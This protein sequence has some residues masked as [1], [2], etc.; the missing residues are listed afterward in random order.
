M[1]RKRKAD[2]EAGESRNG[3]TRSNEED[4]AALLAEDVDIEIDNDD[5]RVDNQ[6]RQDWAA[7]ARRCK[8]SPGSTVWLW[9]SCS[10]HIGTAH[11]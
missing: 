4:A 8:T 7:L 2:Q 11:F 9:Y 10:L 3:R 5:G 1:A 6:R